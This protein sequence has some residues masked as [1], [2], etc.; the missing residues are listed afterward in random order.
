MSRAERGAEQVHRAAEREH[1]NGATREEE[2][3][4]SDRD[5]AA[6]H[7]TLT[8][9]RLRKGHPPGGDWRDKPVDQER[10]KDIKEG[11]SR[12]R[13]PQTAR[14]RMSPEDAINIGTAESSAWGKSWPSPT[15]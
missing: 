8:D 15:N 7:P 10:D 12:R 5:A 11:R 4:K 6:A 2:R 9:T 1:A 14:R 3:R 13:R